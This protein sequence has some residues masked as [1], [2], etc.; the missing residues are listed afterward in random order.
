MDARQIKAQIAELTREYG[1]QEFEVIATIEELFSQHLS[2]WHKQT[3]LVR[4]LE[5]YTLDATVFNSLTGNLESRKVTANS[6]KINSAKGFNSIRRQIAKLLYRKATIKEVSLY[7]Q[8]LHEIVN[9]EVALVDKI[10]GRLYV[11]IELQRGVP[12]TAICEY[13]YQ[14]P[15]MKKNAHYLIGE[16]M[17]FHLNKVEMV[18]FQGVP[19]I[20]VYLDRTS[21]ILVTKL[22]KRELN[23]S[24]ATTRLT[25]VKRIAGGYSLV[26]S[27]QKLPK[28]AILAV[29]RELKEKITV[30]A[31]KE[32]INPDR[33]I[34]A[35][36]KIKCLDLKKRR[37]KNI[38]DQ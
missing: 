6:L 28:E 36:G 26:L 31:T 29:D 34:Y 38:Q 21:R 7:R 13:Q 23:G 16:K 33:I 4:I 17:D 18:E 8:F 19:Q 1:L 2:R 30:F 14:T 37:P 25:C 12:L 35:K 15:Y 22:L 3:V 24:A 5:D 20:N 27:N 32:N 11:E 9:G 10:T